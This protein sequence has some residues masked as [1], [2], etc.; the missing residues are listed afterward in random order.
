MQTIQQM[1]ND[2]NASAGR[3]N[4]QS[5]NSILI[6]NP[7]YYHGMWVFDD[8]RTGLD[9]EPFVAGADLLIEHLLKKLGMLEQG[10]KGFVAVFSKVPF[11]DHQIEL[12]FEKFESM[13]T[14]YTTSETDF[15]NAYG[16]NQIWLCPAL[17]LYFQN[18]PE[19][20]YVQLKIA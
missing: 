15:K 11:P 5:T 16:L 1:L 8:A 20:L 17:N 13:G 9:K 12:K 18:S 2:Y 3:T 7:Y 19:N 10:R 6:I 14:V 4:L